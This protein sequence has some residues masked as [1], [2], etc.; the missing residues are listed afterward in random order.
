M[1]LVDW[2]ALGVLLYEMLAGRIILEKTIR[3]PRSLS[4]K[5]ASVL[6]GF[7][8]K[9]PIDRLGCHRET[10]FQ[11]IT[12]H[13]FFKSID[14]EAIT[15]SSTAF[16]L[17]F[18]Q[19]ECRQVTPPFNPLIRSEIDSDN[20]DPQFTCEP[21]ELT[22]D[23]P[24]PLAMPSCPIQLEQKQ[25]PP[26]YKPRLEGD[27][28]LANFPPEFT[29]EPVHLTP[30]DARV[31]EKIDQTEFEGFEYVNPDDDDDDDCT[32]P[33]VVLGLDDGGQEGEVVAGGVVGVPGVN[34]LQDQEEE[35]EE[36]EEEWLQLQ[37]LHLGGY[38]VG[39]TPRDWI[40][41][42]DRPI[43]SIDSNDGHGTDDD[44]H[45]GGFHGDRQ[46]SR[47]GLQQMFCMSLR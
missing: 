2:W 11:D 36:S 34:V 10:G 1:L 18:L 38:D 43:P 9:N 27:R 21:A 7:L 15:L 20:F 41:T 24:K 42:E 31:I 19:L 28:D 16:L 35:E 40:Q 3:I 8:N 25:V 45:D 39:L 17:L 6:K 13:A 12:G 30:D 14:W 29:D 26:P 47:R 37:R 4:V 22:P 5:A 44:P 32:V 46:G 23:D 33:G